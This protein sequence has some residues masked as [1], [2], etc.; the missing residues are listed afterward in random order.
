MITEEQR[1]IILKALR[2]SYANLTAE[3][4]TEKEFD[5]LTNAMTIV[6]NCS[7]PNVVK[8]LPTKQDVISEGEKQIND[9]LEEN[10]E[11]E[12]QH[13]RVGFR[14]SFEY[15]LRKLK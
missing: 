10:T 2:D 3:N 6:K 13:Y 8:S 15:V 5:N 11:R 12:K 7:I 1:L 9:W 4:M 14:R